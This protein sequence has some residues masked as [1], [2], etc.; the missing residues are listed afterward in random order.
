MILKKVLIG[1]G[2]VVVLLGGGAYFVLS[3]L[4]GF[5]KTA[6]ETYGS[7][8]ISSEVSVGSVEI[9]LTEGSA[10]IYDIS[11]ANPEGFSDQVMMSFSEVSVAIDLATINDPMIVINTITARDPYVLYESANGTTN[12][13]VVSGR[14]ASEEEASEEGATDESAIE[15]SIANILI[16]NIE[17]QMA[18][19]GVPDLSINL[20]DIKLQNLQGTPD[21]IAS[22]LMGP[23]INEAVI[24]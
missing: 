6:I 8:S 11:V 1:L 20:G 24:S 21:E 2:I 7:D 19:E 13:D 4:D 15:L 3:N 5:V 12:V 23:L 9:N 22:Q 16:E 14:F 17:A 18:G 10:F